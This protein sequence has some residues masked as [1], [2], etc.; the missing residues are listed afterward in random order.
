M[1][2]ALYSGGKDSTLAVHKMWEKGVKTDLLISMVSENE[3]S[4]MFH[5]PNVKWTTLQAEAMEIEHVFHY[6]KGEKE[7][8]LADIENALTQNKVTELITGAVASKYQADRINSICKKL[9]INHHAPLWGIDPLVELH[10]LASK[11]DVIV[12]QVSAEGFDNNILGKRIDEKMIQR[13][14]ELHNRYRINMLFE[15]GE[16]ES[17]VRDAPLFKKSIEIKKARTEWS[18]QVGKYIIEEAELHKK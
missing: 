15:G 11:F 18:G 7:K 4:Y 6:T 5:R 10:E 14:V 13:L 2:A 17:F 9:G 16:A 3:F 1:I 8:E 12:T